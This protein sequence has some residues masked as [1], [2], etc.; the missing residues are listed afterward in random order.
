ME[1]TTEIKKEWYDMLFEYPQLKNI[2]DAEKQELIK[3][4]NDIDYTAHELK[5]HIFE[6]LRKIIWDLV[7]PCDD[8]IQVY[9][10]VQ[11]LQEVSAAIWILN[12]KKLPNIE[13]LINNYLDYWTEDPKRLCIPLFTD[14]SQG[15][16]FHEAIGNANFRF[17]NKYAL[18]VIEQ[19]NKELEHENK[20]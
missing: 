19:M 5:L 2:S 1:T 16:N 10:L 11:T 12:D 6:K 3:Y 13:W 4:F 9:L 7:W 15:K 18:Y 8:I 14:G 20:D 17:V